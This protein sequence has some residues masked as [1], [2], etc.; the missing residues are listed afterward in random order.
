MK[1]TLRSP[2]S[3][4]VAV[5]LLPRFATARQAAPNAGNDAKENR[6]AKVVFYILFPDCFRNEKLGLR[7]DVVDRQHRK[8]VR[9]ED[10]IRLACSRV[11][12]RASVKVA[13]HLGVSLEVE[14]LSLV[15]KLLAAQERL[16][17][18]YT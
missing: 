7:A 4:S 12:R 15:E 8:N 16:S 10:W 17:S 13:I 5:G 6:N 14:H 1:S 18:I 3:A 11:R 9:P 2:N